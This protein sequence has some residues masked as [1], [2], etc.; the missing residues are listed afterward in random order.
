MEAAA[1]SD[2]AKTF[3]Q[4]VADAD[5]DPEERE[6]LRQ[7]A[8]KLS[9]TALG[10]IDRMLTAARQKHNSRR[11]DETRNRQQAARRDPRP[12]IPVPFPDMPF[13]PV[14]GVLNDV[15]GEVIAAVPPLRDIDGVTTRV[16][17]LPIPNMHPFTQ[18]EGDD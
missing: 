18:S 15:I 9:G 5:L 11:A 7:L 2:V 16:R 10:A 14:M 4:L 8:K 13:L 1:K 3:C 17:K 6:E 12:S